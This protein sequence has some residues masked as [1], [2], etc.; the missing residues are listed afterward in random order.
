MPCFQ[1][2]INIFA[3]SDFLEILLGCFCVFI[4]KQ[5][6]DKVVA[7]LLKNKAILIIIIMIS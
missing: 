1:N 2:S 6:N 4:S 7:K 3:L 5:L